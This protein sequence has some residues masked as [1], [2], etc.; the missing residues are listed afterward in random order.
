MKR[1]GVLRRKN[2]HVKLT[3][4]TH[5]AFKMRLLEHDV[6][7]QRAFEA[8]AEAVADGWQPAINIVIREVRRKLKDELLSVG[9]KPIDLKRKLKAPG[10]VSELDADTLYDLISDDEDDSE[11]PND[12][13]EP[14]MT[15]GHHHEAA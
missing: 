8:F 11:S 13:E 5:T 3:R 10:P 15:Q 7:M 9:I 6:P 2:I 4:E 12:D 1:N 14:P